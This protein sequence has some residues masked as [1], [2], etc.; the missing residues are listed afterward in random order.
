MMFTTLFSLATTASLASAASLQQVTN[1]GANPSNIKMHIY[2]PDKLAAS[3]AIVVALHPCGGTAQQWYSGTR[4][5][6]YADSNGF[7]IIYPSTPNY[8]NCWDV[9]DAKSLTH[10]AG[11]DSLSIINMINYTL[12]KYKGDKAKVFVMGSSSGAMMTNVMAG[13]Y[14]EY[15]EAGAAYSGTAHACFAGAGG[16]TPFSPNQT[17]A[18]GLSR[19]P[20][21][22]ANFVYNSYPGYTGKRPRMQI[23]HGNADT[24][25][26]PACAHEA[27]KQWSKV[28]DI[29]WAK[30]VTGV[31]S[32]QYQN[33]V[34]GDGT[35]LQGFFGTGVGH[36][37][38]VNEQLMFKFFG[39]IP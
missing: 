17:C 24:L 11:G 7:I 10:G 4:M 5:P 30:N 39:I 38:P 12:D 9:H 35:K 32:A 8:S 15:F 14:P 2:V 3:P 20:E 18:Q 25:V 27:L 22:W 34:Y 1:W 33:V 21:Q 26:R 31:P 28:L 36:T 29:P 37:A 16:N 19:T 23:Y 13:T 6:S